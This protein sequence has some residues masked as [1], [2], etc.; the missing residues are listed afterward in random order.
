[1]KIDLVSLCLVMVTN[2]TQKLIHFINIKVVQ[3]SLLRAQ[4]VVSAAEG[5]TL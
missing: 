5:A 4:L 1:M 2:Q 3:E